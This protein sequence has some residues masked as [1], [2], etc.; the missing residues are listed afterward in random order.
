MLYG[1]LVSYLENEHFFWVVSRKKTL[2]WSFGGQKL[3]THN[4]WDH[5]PNLHK[6]L[7]FFCLLMKKIWGGGKKDI[8]PS[9]TQL[10][11]TIIIFLLTWGLSSMQ[12]LPV[13]FDSP[14][15]ESFQ[16]KIGPKLTDLEPILKLLL[17]QVKFHEIFE[18]SKKAGFWPKNNFFLIFLSNPRWV[19]MFFEGKPPKKFCPE[20]VIENRLYANI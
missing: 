16:S 6:F 8:G 20:T 9:S 14:S 1:F 13:L 2:I 4:F 11:V 18:G 3:M 17:F 12:N 15:K 19:I 7:D 5:H 10:L